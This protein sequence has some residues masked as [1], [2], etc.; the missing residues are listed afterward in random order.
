VPWNRIES[1]E[2]GESLMKLSRGLWHWLH[3]PRF[4][5]GGQCGARDAQ[6]GILGQTGVL[7]PFVFSQ[8]K[9]SLE[10]IAPGP[11]QS[12]Q[13]IALSVDS[14]PELVNTAWGWVAWHTK[15]RR[16]ASVS[17]SSPGKNSAGMAGSP[18]VPT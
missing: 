13:P 14:G 8:G 9:H 7:G 10:V 12:S 3:N 6:V 5:T 4:Q 15:Q 16:T 1:G 11:W 18:G 2:P 17:G